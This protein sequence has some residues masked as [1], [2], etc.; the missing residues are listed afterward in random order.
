MKPILVT[1]GAKGLGAMLCKQLAARGHEIVIH[2][3]KSEREAESTMK[4]CQNLGVMAETIQG[5]FSTTSSLDLFT[6]EYL[7]RF[8]STKGIVNNVGN[9]LISLPSKVEKEDWQSLF[10]T[11][12]FAP[13]SLIQ[14]ILPQLKQE[15]GRIVNLGTSGLLPMKAFL[16]ITAYAITKSALWLYTRSLAK[17]LANDHITV[18]MVSPGFLETAIDLDKNSKFVPILPMGRPAKL[19]EVA[20]V[21]TFFFEP[22]NQYITGQNIEVAGGFGL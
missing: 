19:E 1:G 5:D 3:H 16:N 8:P 14:S 21:V 11:N 9:Y 10:Q 6:Q 2:F 20:S 13:V 4:V 18:N 22:E 15:K 17:E 12:F 7:D